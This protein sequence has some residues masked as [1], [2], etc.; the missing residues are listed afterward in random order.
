M[1]PPTE[2][3]Q[4]AF[5]QCR[6]QGG[7]SAASD[8]FVKGSSGPKSTFKP[9]DRSRQIP[10]FHGINYLAD[11]PQQ[12][13]FLPLSKPIRLDH[14]KLPFLGDALIAA[15]VPRNQVKIGQSVARHIGQVRRIFLIVPTGSP[16]AESGCAARHTPRLDSRGLF[17]LQPQPIGGCLQ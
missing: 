14:K 12:D 3:G 17:D 1:P 5:H 16:D 9:R 2:H 11:C 4:R 8:T 6:L 15:R 13:P 7:C 10:A